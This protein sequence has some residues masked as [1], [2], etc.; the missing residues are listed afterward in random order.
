MAVGSEKL[1]YEIQVNSTGASQQLKDFDKSVQQLNKSTQNISK[2]FDVFKGILAGYLS[3]QGAKAFLQ[4]AEGMQE[5]QT[6]LVILTGS[7]ETALAVQEELFVIAQKQNVALKDL[8]KAYIKI[9]PALQEQGKSQAEILKF[10]DALISSYKLIGQS[11]DEAAQSVSNLADA[12]ASG[13]IDSGQLNQVL[14]TN[15]EL[16]KSVSKELG[17]TEKE[18]RKLARAGKVSGEDLFRSVTKSADEWDKRASQL[19]VGISEALTNLGNSLAKLATQ[20][21][22]VIDIIA[23]G[24]LFIA[25][26]FEAVAVGVGTF[27]AAIL[28][29]TGAVTGLNIALLANPI[30]LAATALAAA[31][32]LIYK[33]WDGIKIFFYSLFT[34]DIPNAIDQGKIAFL[35]FSTTFFGE[36]VQS[37]LGKW[38]FF[39]NGIIKGYNL[40]A[41]KLDWEKISEVS[42]TVTKDEATSRI[43]E[44]NKQIEE[45]NLAL[46]KYILG[47]EKVDK[48]STNLLSKKPTPIPKLGPEGP[49]EGTVGADQEARKI[50][51]KELD[52]LLKGL[53]TN[54]VWGGFKNGVQEAILKVPT[55]AEGMNKI[56]EDL[57]NGMTESLTN[58][59]KTG[60]LELKDLFTSISDAL[61]KLGIQKAIVAGISAIGFSKGGVFEKGNVTPFASG[62]VINKPTIFPFA[63]GIGLMGEK[64]PEAIMPLHRDSKGS[65]GV[66][67]GGNQTVV[68]VYNQTKDS[69][70]ET[71]ESEDSNGI[72]KIDVFITQRIK[73]A[74]QTGQMDKTMQ[75]NYGLSRAGVR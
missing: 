41:E 19:P 47:L 1:I 48:I 37:I 27:T 33:N 30:T 16:L 38:E 20:F 4:L 55:I 66:K 42:F 40:L 56:G 51:L 60:K 23:K 59:V 57:F 2:T 72:K 29:A 61:I 58:F 46:D 65:L 26:N 71:K 67:G 31:A 54:D 74:F 52:T 22:P 36:V 9:A 10:T 25:D 34:T 11:T 5:A 18:L 28:I 73:N 43:A 35:E 3:F 6:R 69:E 75:N 7:M 24:L 17:V 15:R 70:V 64:G 50:A 32:I 12:Y 44:I 62:G 14:L 8:S 63:S 39:V 53:N 45:R 68:N 21:A 13:K 49:A